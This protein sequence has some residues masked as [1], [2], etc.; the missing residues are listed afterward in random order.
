MKY[1]LANLVL[2]DLK[3]LI[4]TPAMVVTNSRRVGG[5][6]LLEPA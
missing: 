2:S 3:G 4:P 1:N 5:C 6:A